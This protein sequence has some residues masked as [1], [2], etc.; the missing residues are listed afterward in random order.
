MLTYGSL[1]VSGPYNVPVIPCSCH[2][3]TKKSAPSVKIQE[4]FSSRVT[5]S[6]EHKHVYLQSDVMRKSSKKKGA[7]SLLAW[8]DH[9]YGRKSHLCGSSYEEVGAEMH[10]F[11]S[12]QFS[13]SL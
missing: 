9:I 5:T 12:W 8:L 7:R 11:L 6:S 13:N 4:L 10:V 1:F 3:C 2:C